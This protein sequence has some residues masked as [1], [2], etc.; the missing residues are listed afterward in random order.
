M[1]RGN[2]N[3][4]IKKVQVANFNVV[5]LEKQ[6][7][8]PLLQYFDTIVMPALKSGIKRIDGDTSYLFTDIE[9][10][11]DE[12]IGFVLAG[13]I[14]K[15]TMIEIKSDLD[16]EGNLIDKDDKYSAAPY[17]AFAIYL[18]NHRMVYVQNQKGS[19][20]IKTFSSVVKYVLSQYIRQ[21]NEEQK[22]E[23]EYLPFPYINI[24]GIPMRG[25]IEKALK[26]VSKIT[27]LTLRFYPLNGDQE[28]GDM[29]GTLISDM[30]KASGSKN[31]EVVLK[32]PKNING[33][34]NIVEESSGTVK[35]IIEVMYPNKTK[36]KITEDTISERMEMDFPGENIQ[37]VEEVISKGKRIEN[38]NFV[39]DGN[40]KIYEEYRSKII[41]FLPRN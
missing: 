34:I 11:E 14:V 35:P 13:N 39:S 2:C 4:S 1:F 23:D 26:D 15:K 33:V 17:S 31:G 40:K 22:N 41:K 5:F 20:T 18:R 21:Y 28:F 29:F 6:N 25:N 8:A 27:R 24:V 36:G 10:I 37:E 19:P 7:E 16:I 9:I 30:R 32:S 12:E 3:M 38:I